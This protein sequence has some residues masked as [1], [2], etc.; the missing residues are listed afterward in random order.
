MEVL[1]GVGG[2]RFLRE[3]VGGGSCV[4]AYSVPLS[5]G[6][7]ACGVMRKGRREGSKGSVV[8]HILS[9]LGGESL[10]C[11]HPSHMGLD[12]SVQL[13]KERRGGNNTFIQMVCGY[14]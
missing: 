2:W 12:I 4:C 7:A 5:R 3:W 6:A 9:G 14:C 13:R 11:G 10:T 8:S 1:E